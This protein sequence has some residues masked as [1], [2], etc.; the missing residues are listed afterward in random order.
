MNLRNNRGI[1]LTIL[2]VILII[3]VIAIST[4]FIMI[5]KH[6]QSSI[7]SNEND[8]NSTVSSARKQRIYWEYN[9]NDLKY[10]DNSLIIYF[11]TFANIQN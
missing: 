5:S 9:I 10:N 7:I 4:L 2:I 1:S 6:R 3:I 8:S 11:Y